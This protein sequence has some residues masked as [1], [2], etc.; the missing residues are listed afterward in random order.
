MSDW[1]YV[2]LAFTIVWGALAVYALLLARRVSQARSLAEKLRQGELL[3]DEGDNVACD[4][5]PA[6]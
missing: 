4:A 1:A 5:P 2:A 6:P 3:P